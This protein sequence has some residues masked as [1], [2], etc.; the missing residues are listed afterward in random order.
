[1]LR[2]CLRPGFILGILTVSLTGFFSC[3]LP[4]I[5]LTWWFSSAVIKW[6]FHSFN[7]QLLHEVIFYKWHLYCFFSIFTD[8]PFLKGCVVW[9]EGR[10]EA[11][12]IS[13]P[14]G[15][16]SSQLNLPLPFTLV[17]V[18]CLIIDSVFSLGTSCSQVWKQLVLRLV[19]CLTTYRT[20]GL[21]QLLAFDF[22]C[23]R[24]CSNVS[25]LAFFNINMSE[26][27]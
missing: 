3:W 19:G 15:A 7:W 22:C 4:R 23:R 24:T 27:V 11:T 14:T 18:S 13:H 5:L 16:S 9:R 26:E 20:L 10:G 1:M 8:R 17:V 6:T 2:I 12:G 21:I 25:T